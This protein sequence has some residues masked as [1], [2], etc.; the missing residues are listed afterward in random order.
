MSGSLLQKKILTLIIINFL[1]ALIFFCPQKVE[2]T[3][4]KSCYTQFIFLYYYPELPKQLKQ[5]NSCSKMW[6]IDQLYIKLGLTPA[7]KVMSHK[8]LQQAQNLGLLEP[9]GPPDRTYKGYL[10]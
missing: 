3:T 7:L 5:K 1:D 2:K 6:L 8:P 4:L 9:T 10:F